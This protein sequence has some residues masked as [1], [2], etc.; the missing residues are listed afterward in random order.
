MN[1][2]VW[3][4]IWIDDGNL[5]AQAYE[6]EAAALR[7]AGEINDEFSVVESTVQR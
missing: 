2:K 7:D 3:I 4:V 6:T 5:N 1:T